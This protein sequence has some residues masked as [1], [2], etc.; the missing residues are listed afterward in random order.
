VDAAECCAVA[1]AERAIAARV[2]ALLVCP[3]L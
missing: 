2:R 3:E 1:G